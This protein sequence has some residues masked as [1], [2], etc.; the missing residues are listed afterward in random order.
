VF[1]SWVSAGACPGAVGVVGG[2]T[3]APGALGAGDGVA[4]AADGVGAADPP[5]TLSSSDI[6]PNLW[7]RG[8]FRVGIGRASQASKELH[9]MRRMRSEGSLVDLIE[10]GLES[11]IAFVGGLVKFLLL[12]QEVVDGTPEALASGLGVSSFERLNFVRFGYLRP[13]LKVQRITQTID[14]GIHYAGPC[15]VGGP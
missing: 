12:V 6:F 1:G 5:V 9:E 13:T 15:V 7:Y 11:W 3:E 4:G 10:V 2:A 8:Q 14:R